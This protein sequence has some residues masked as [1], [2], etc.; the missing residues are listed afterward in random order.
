MTIDPLH[1]YKFFAKT[2][3]LVV[4]AMKCDFNR[5]ITRFVGIV[6]YEMDHFSLKPIV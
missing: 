1:A 2:N 3:S 6:V 4:I 5:N